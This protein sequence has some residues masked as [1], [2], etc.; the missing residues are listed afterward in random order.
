MGIES[1]L[2]LDRLMKKRGRGLLLMALS[3][4][5]HTLY[6]KIVVII[7]NKELDSIT[8]SITMKNSNLSKKN[9]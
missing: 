7:N 3:C 4:F 5:M 2:S 1:H 6:N 9:Q 8:K